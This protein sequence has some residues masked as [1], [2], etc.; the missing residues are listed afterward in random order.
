M[1][2]SASPSP[3]IPD[4]EFD[5]DAVFDVCLL[6]TVLAARRPGLAVY[7]I[8]EGALP[9]SPESGQKTISVAGAKIVNEG[10]WR[11]SY[12]GFPL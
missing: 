3:S 7:V 2:W 5:S 12:Q 1:K 4:Y 9:V 11:E 8:L 6:A 10:A